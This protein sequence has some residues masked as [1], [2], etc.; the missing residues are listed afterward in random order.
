MA[1][2]SV[3]RPP[4]G[5]ESAGRALWRAMHEDLGDDLEFDARERVVLRDACRQAD[6][7]AALARAIRRDG[8][9]VEGSQGQPR[10][11][12]AVTELRQG[13][14]AV[15]R[16]LGDLDLSAGDEQPRTAASL[17]A[18]RAAQARWADREPRRRA[19]G[20]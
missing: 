5:L 12:A 13:R 3:Q 6:V 11:N 4:E 10:L 2:R 1:D 19:D 15:A 17:R 14:L 9:V 18:Q 8:V 20:P 7:N 16:L